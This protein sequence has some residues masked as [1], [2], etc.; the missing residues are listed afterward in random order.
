MPQIHRSWGGR[1][2]IGG[3]GLGGGLLGLDG[4]G[5][6]GLRC[7]RWQDQL[8]VLQTGHEAMSLLAGLQSQTMGSLAPGR[9]PTLV[10]F[11]QGNCAES[12]TEAKPTAR[13]WAWKQRGVSGNA[14]Q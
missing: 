9:H 7:S 3:A 1:A 14:R 13:V 8:P 5:G 11:P 4:W 12:T 2:S 10:L 6:R